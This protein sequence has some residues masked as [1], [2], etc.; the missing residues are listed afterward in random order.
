MT[1]AARV[2]L[3]PTDPAPEPG[4]AERWYELL[5]ADDRARAERLLR[6]ADRERSVLAHAFL[7]LCLSRDSSVP[8]TSW[9]FERDGHGRPWVAGRGGPHFSLSHSRGLTAVLVCEQP[10]CGVDVERIDAVQDPLLVARRSFSPAEQAAL[11][12]A[13]GP[14]RRLAFTER[15]TLKEAW[16]K[17]RGLGMELPFD[18]AGFTVEGGVTVSFL[19][20][21]DD[22]ADWSFTLARP[23]EQHVL[24]VA[25][26][27]GGCDE[28]E[29][30]TWRPSMLP[31]TP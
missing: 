27:G 18:K 8:P 1:P 29:M 31:L 21:I 11:A 19:D 20:G 2:W 13:T 10:R 17:A 12:A 24:A 15:W 30:T 28:I 25:M 5:D 9:R 4:L 22:P 23:T 14:A 3:L 16:A 26:G 7:R 6:P